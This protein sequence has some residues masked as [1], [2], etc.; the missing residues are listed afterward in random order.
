MGPLSQQLER[1]ALSLR[2]QMSMFRTLQESVRGEQ[3]FVWM[4]DTYFRDRFPKLR[5]TQRD[6][7]IAGAMFA[8][9]IK[10]EGQIDIANLPMARSRAARKME[11]EEDIV[12]PWF[13]RRRQS[14]HA[15]N[16]NKST[17]PERA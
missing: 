12:V 9:G 10:D 2:A 8:S 17:A 1:D 7:F 4:L 15:P 6:V 3:K 11:Y 5:K 14:K 16:L 13:K